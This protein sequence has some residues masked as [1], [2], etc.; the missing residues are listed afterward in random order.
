MRRPTFIRLISASA[1]VGPTNARAQVYPTKSL[2]IVSSYSPEDR[3][4]PC[5]AFWPSM[6]LAGV[7]KDC[8]RL[9]APYPG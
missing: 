6:K 5:L 3:P 8:A 9:L 1:I 7:L 2:T 4:T